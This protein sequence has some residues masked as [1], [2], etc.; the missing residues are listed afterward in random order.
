MSNVI[1]KSDLIRCHCKPIIWMVCGFLKVITV[2]VLP[3]QVAFALVS[4]CLLLAAY[5][6][7]SSL[8]QSSLG[9]ICL[10]N[11]PDALPSIPQNVDLG[12]VRHIKSTFSSSSFTE[13]ET[14][15]LYLCSEKSSQ[16]LCFLR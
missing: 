3:S 9:W 10:K 6:I 5:H 15:R 16:Y 1:G 14:S 12:N 4:T 13:C 2:K 7:D 8:T 11:L